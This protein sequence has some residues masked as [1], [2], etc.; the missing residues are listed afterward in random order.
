M[1]G[2][3]HTNTCKHMDWRTRV[4]FEGRGEK[5]PGGKEEAG[6]GRRWGGTIW[7]PSMHLMHLE[8]LTPAAP[9][10]QL[11]PQGHRVSCSLSLE[12]PA[13]FFTPVPEQQCPV[14]LRSW[15]LLFQPLPWAKATCYL[16]DLPGTRRAAKLTGK[17]TC[18]LLP[19]PLPLP[20][21]HPQLTLALSTLAGGSGAIA[22]PCP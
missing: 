11:R 3:Q 9:V 18:V 10:L 13:F 1:G 5:P 6:T 16:L 21:A 2:R 17:G 15:L 14:P 12:T 22:L 4:S 19:L 8:S 20:S 7:S